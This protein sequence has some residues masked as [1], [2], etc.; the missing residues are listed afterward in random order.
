MC[1]DIS[2]HS[3]IELT[4][5]AFPGLV[6][7][8]SVEGFSFK[9]QVPAFLFPSMPIISRQGVSL[10]LSDMDWGVNPTY[11][12][13]P[14]EREE[15]RRSMVN[16][17][18][19]RILEDRKSYWYRIRDNR[20][21]IPVSGTFEHRAI[22]GWKKKVP[23]YIWLKERELHYLPGLYQ[24]CEAVDQHGEI[25]IDWSFTMI[26]RWGNEVMRGIHN[27]G[28][29]KHRMPLFL[30]PELEQAWISEKLTESQMTEIF[31]FEMPTEAMG[32]RPVYSL[33][34]AADR[35]DGKHKYDQWVWPNLPI[36]K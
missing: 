31:A 12:S 6:N 8:R 36:R 34:G 9:D 30:T 28:E 19:E 33:R 29:N 23:Y 7:K 10:V 13:N 24:V 14:K 26:T 27:D 1:W 32:Y 20:C 22:I 2:L 15:R 21:L 17:R 4:R 16:A 5:E 11:L 25:Y 35:P 18:S 3:D